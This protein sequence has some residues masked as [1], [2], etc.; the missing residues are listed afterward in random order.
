M[1]GFIIQLLSEI[2]LILRRTKRDMIKMCI[3]LYVKC[4]LFLSDFND[5]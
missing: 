5:I 3:V 2:F 1:G 4:P